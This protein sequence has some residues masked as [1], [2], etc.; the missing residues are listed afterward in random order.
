M[1]TM[2]TEG[3]KF[4]L[5]STYMHVERFGQL[6]DNQKLMGATQATVNK[7]AFQL[8][9]KDA[10][11]LAPEYAKTVEPTEKRREAELVISPHPV[12]DVWRNGYPECLMM[13][14]RKDYFRFVELLQ[15]NPQEKYFSFEP[16]N[17]RDVHKEFDTREYESMFNDWALFR[18]S[19]ET[20]R[21]GITRLNEY[22]YRRMRG[23]NLNRSYYR[24]RDK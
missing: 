7:I 6:G 9:V 11:E 12:E 5:A 23:N 22:Y 21:E 2:V 10:E 8:T 13:Q 3:R 4:G 20:I 14:N 17:P 16:S 18:S 19:A 1:A 24:K 15:A